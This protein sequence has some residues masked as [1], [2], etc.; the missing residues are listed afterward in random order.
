[1]ENQDNIPKA[2]SDQIHAVVSTLALIDEALELYLK[3]K[4]LREEIRATRTEKKSKFEMKQDMIQDDPDYQK[5]LQNKKNIKIKEYS[6]KLALVKEEIK[7]SRLKLRQSLN[8][9]LKIRAGLMQGEPLHSKVNEKSIE[10]ALEIKTKVE[11]LKRIRNLLEFEIVSLNEIQN[12]KTHGME[13]DLSEEEILDKFEEQFPDKIDKPKEA[14]KTDD[15]KVKHLTDSM[16]AGVEEE[17]GREGDQAAKEGGYR[18]YWAMVKKPF[19]MLA[20]GVVTFFG[21]GIFVP[22]LSGFNELKD[23]WHSIT[24]GGWRHV[25]N[26]ITKGTLILAGGVGIGYGVALGVAAIGTAALLANPLSLAGIGVLLGVLAAASIVANVFKFVSKFAKIISDKLFDKEA[27]IYAPTVSL[28]KLKG[29]KQAYEIAKFFRN[30]IKSIRNAQQAAPTPKEKQI[31]DDIEKILEETFNTLKNTHDEVGFNKVWV[32]A[33]KKIHNKHQELHYCL[34]QGHVNRVNE[35]VNK[36]VVSKKPKNKEKRLHELDVTVE[37]NR[38][39]II[40]QLKLVQQQW[41]QLKEKSSYYVD[42]EEE[43]DERPYIRPEPK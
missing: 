16:A 9:M 29:K 17:I 27:D 32:S 18:I 10:D 1:M 8:E 40:N 15:E 24:H 42:I 36:T 28:I 13:F 11:E 23:A 6:D 25:A 34:I 2:E 12:L 35:R 31:Y 19:L 26:G 43:I 39:S 20:A 41:A 22:L 3:S 37:E 33:M 7:N 5:E 4:K 30:E 21:K 14:V 38:T